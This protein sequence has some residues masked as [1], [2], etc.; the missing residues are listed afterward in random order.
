MQIG[1]LPEKELTVK[2]PLLL[3]VKTIK[4]SGK[5]TEAHSKKLQEVFFNKEKI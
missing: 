2:N 1:D 4:N 5:R 3:I